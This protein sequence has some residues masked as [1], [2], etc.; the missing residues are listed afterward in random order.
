MLE[1]PGLKDKFFIWF[2][3][4]FARRPLADVPEGV[5]DAELIR[6]GE[7]VQRRYTLLTYLT[8]ALVT[9]SVGLLCKV[10][11]LAPQARPEDLRFLSNSIWLPSFVLAI[12]L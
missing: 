9:V 2:I 11:G 7:L 4:P 3:R 1:A 10:S 5:T 6:R 8:L 12:G